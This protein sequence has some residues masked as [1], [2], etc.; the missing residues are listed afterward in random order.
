MATAPT[1]PALKQAFITT[2]TNLLSQPVAPSRAWRISNDASDQPIPERLVD[3]ALASLNHTIQQH[4]RRVYAPQASRNVAEQISNAYSRDVERKV[5]GTDDAEGAL[6]E[7]HDE[8]IEA[9]PETW[10]SEKDINAYPMEANRYKEAVQQ[11]ADLNEQRKALRLRVERLRRLQSTIEPLRTTDG[12]VG[13]QENLATRDGP[14]EKE[15]EKMRFLLAR[16]AGR[17]GVLSSARASQES[18]SVELGDLTEARKRNI[19]EF[20]ADPKVFPSTG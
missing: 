9:L 19:D 6:E 5:G 2:Q 18:S 11:L 3:E 12:G 14:V 1:I 8:A 17:V 20:L 15:L 16:V 10:S 4:C 7:T 13:V